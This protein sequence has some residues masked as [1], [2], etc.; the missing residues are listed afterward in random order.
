M[1]Q[2]SPRGNVPLVYGVLRP[3]DWD[4]DAAIQHMHT[5]DLPFDLPPGMYRLDV[6]LRADDECSLRHTLLH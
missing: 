6:A 5:L 2:P 1:A 3:S 4:G